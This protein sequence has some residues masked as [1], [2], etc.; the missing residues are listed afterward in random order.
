MCRR[1]TS[2][3]TALDVGSEFGIGEALGQQV[4]RLSRM[5]SP[6]RIR[7]TNCWLKMRNFSRFSFLRPPSK[8]DPPTAPGAGF[9]G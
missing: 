9:D 2:S 7:V 8:P 6:A 3:R 5:G 1:A 4:Q